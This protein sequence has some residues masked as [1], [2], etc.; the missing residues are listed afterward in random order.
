EGA[1]AIAFDILFPEPDPARPELLVQLYP[2]LGKQTAAEV[3]ALEPMDRLFGKVIGLSPV[4]LARAGSAPD[5]SN[6]KTAMVDVEI[7][8][9]PPPDLDQWPNIIT[10]IPELDDN[11]L[12]HGLINSQ[13]D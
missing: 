11:A 8:G 3:A 4:V 2:E 10:S 7:K 6:G 12:G 9:T 5:A 13:P 1:K